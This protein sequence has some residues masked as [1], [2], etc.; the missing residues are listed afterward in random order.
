MDTVVRLT[1]EAT[2][3]I[4]GAAVE[5]VGKAEGER[6]K[7]RSEHDDRHIKQMGET[8]YLYWVQR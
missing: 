6:Q 4:T 2:L 5:K 8:A 1:F 3:A 7:T